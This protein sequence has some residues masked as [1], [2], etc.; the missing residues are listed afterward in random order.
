[1]SEPRGTVVRP[2]RFGQPASGAARAFVHT[3]FASPHPSNPC[4]IRE[5]QR[6]VPCLMLAHT[7]VYTDVASMR[8]VRER[9]VFWFRRIPV[10]LYSTLYAGGGHGLQG[11]GLG[12]DPPPFCLYG[13]DL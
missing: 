8:F 2:H 4:R 5:D 3:G 7:D 1:M 9:A 13:S 11:R 6:G 10:A 12:W